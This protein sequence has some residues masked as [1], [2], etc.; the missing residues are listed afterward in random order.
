MEPVFINKFKHTKENYIEMNKAYSF[1]TRMIFGLFFL[2]VYLALAFFIYFYLYNL[3]TAIIIAVIGVI[4]AFYPA[5]KIRIIAHKREK[6]FL[7]LYGEIPKGKTL[8]FEDHLF[9][10]SETDKAELNLDYNKII[11]VKQSK[12]MYLLI[13]KNKLIVFVDKNSFERGTC[14]EFE[15]FIKEKAANA[16]IKL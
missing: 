8:F 5:A 12:N 3:I 10:V 2:I 4:L 9:S 7:E 16:K 6:K 1:L 14:E 11:K 13:L 15:K